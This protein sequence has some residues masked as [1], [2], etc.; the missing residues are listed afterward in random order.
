MLFPV[1]LFSQWKYRTTGQDKMSVAY[2][3]ILSD[4]END[5]KFLLWNNK[6]SLVPDDKYGGVDFMIDSDYFKEDEKY[7]ISFLIDTSRV[8]KLDKYKVI[9]GYLIMKS[10][11]NENGEKKDIYDILNKIKNSLGCVITIINDSNKLELFS[12]STDSSEAIDYVL[13]KPQL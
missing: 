12:N 13:D 6:N 11:I 9:D 3:E 7:E 2:A 1:I 8:V 10:F 5:F 4:T